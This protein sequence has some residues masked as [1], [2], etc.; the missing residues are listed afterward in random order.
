MSAPVRMP[1]LGESAI[2]GTILRWL[3]QP[4]DSVARDEPL[5]EVMTDKVTVEIPSPVAGVLVRQWAAVGETVP[6]GAPPRGDQS[7]AC[8]NAH[9]LVQPGSTQA[10]P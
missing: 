7:W 4:G 1:Q 3:K 6:V 9:P 2:E 5:V 10:G 8:R